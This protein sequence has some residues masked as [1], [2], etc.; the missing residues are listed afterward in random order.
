MLNRKLILFYYSIKG[1]IKVINVL[2]KEK[3]FYLEIKLKKYKRKGFI[4]TNRR[5][6]LIDDLSHRE[7]VL[8]SF[9]HEDF[10]LSLEIAVEEAAILSIYVNSIRFI[11]L[12]VNEYSSGVSLF[13]EVH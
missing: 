5:E 6:K 12:H 3:N 11:K 4:L 8:E 10:N 13:L 9:F 7:K 1:S 2:L